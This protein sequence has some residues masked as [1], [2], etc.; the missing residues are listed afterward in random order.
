MK[1]IA[2]LTK[3][4]E[5]LISSERSARNMAYQGFF[6]KDGEINVKLQLIGE[7]DTK[8]FFEPAS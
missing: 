3:G 7:V 8:I 2:T 5:V 6:D 4:G 1:Y